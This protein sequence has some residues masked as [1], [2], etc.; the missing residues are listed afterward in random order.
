MI[1]KVSVSWLGHL[2]QMAPWLVRLLLLF[3]LPFPR[4][5]LFVARSTRLTKVVAKHTWYIPNGPLEGYKL[6]SLLPDEI[7]PVLTNSMEIRC[8]NLLRNLPHKSG[9]ALDVGG[10]YGYYALLL[11][12]LVG[13]KERVFSFEPD[14]RTF[15]RL[16]H[17][18]AINNVRNVVAVPIC[19]SN[20]SAGLE[21]WYSSDEEP[22]KSHLQDCQAEN[23]PRELM[24][25]VPV[26]ALDDFAST[27]NILERIWLIKI[28]VE[29]TELKV[30]EGAAQL[31]DKS[32]PLLL[33]ELHG[34]EIAKQVFRFLLGKKY[35]WEM[36]EYMGETR[37]H[38]LAFPADQAD[39][40][41]A[42][43]L[44]LEGC[45]SDGDIRE[46]VASEV[47]RG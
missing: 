18:L 26:V 31:L 41:R 40:Y 28:D 13:E 25:A 5:Y 16:T 34:A 21:R 33:C 20:L 7:G 46:L 14:W 30:L 6:D 38:I 11:A 44:Q 42:L 2:G 8:S 24:T 23:D 22:W 4:M 32:T 27:L 45:S 37:Q 29:G 3:V 47:R 9:I 43:V 1:R 10:S 17:N 15:E 19:V 12:R 35:Q 39:R 36:I